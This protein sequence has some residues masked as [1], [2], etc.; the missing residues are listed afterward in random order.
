MLKIGTKAPDFDLLSDEG[1]QV[2]LRDLKGSVVILYFYPKDDT[3]GCTKQACE[4][5]DDFS[6]YKKAGIAVYGISLDTVESHKK[7]R[8]KYE[9]PFPLLAD[10]DAIASK[11]YDVYR[12][13]SMY[14][15]T[16]WGID[17]TTYVL[18]K[19]GVIQA[20]FPRVKVEGHSKEL[21][22]NLIA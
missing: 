20:I 6:K 13:K 12:Q 21:L 7:F 14:G 22:A 15:K 8:A 17:R 19:E 11:A 18:N 3:P 5:R 10:T 1:K 16:F 9:L 2:R 4:F